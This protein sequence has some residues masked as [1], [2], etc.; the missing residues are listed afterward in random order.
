M[1]MKSINPADQSVIGEVKVATKQDVEKA[2]AKAKKASEAWRNT[3]TKKRASYV[4]KLAKEI[5]K[6]KEKVARLST[7]EMGKPYSESLDD[8]D[9]DQDYLK[10]YVQEGPKILQDEII[11][12]TKKAIRKVV[13]EPFGVCAVITPWNYPLGMPIW[14][15]MPNLLAGNAVVFKPSEH[16]PLCGQEVVDILEKVG[17][18]NGVVNIIHG[19]GKIGAMLVDSDVD[20]VWFTGSSRVGQKIY[21]LYL[22]AWW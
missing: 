20:M 22:R 5:L 2:V 19:D 18:P 16:T 8:V 12:K 9:W 13:H 15:I 14:G 6:R 21:S 7:L 10:F 4:D 3:P 1:R 11:E 17:L